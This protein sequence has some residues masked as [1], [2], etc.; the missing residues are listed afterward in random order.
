M[1]RE[2]RGGGVSSFDILTNLEGMKEDEA[3]MLLLVVVV[4]V[5]LLFSK[6]C[7]LF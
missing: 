4:V 5:A 7:L 6:T 2:T 1:E 3:I